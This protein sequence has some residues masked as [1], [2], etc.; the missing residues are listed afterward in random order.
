[1]ASDGGT[2]D[3]PIYNNFVEQAKKLEPR[4]L[5]MVIPSR[6]MASGLG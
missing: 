4:Y 3:I 2:R 1:M 6:W 5:S